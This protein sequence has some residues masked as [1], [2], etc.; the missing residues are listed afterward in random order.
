M[1]RAATVQRGSQAQVVAAML[2]D[3]ITVDR[4]GS[5]AGT[6]AVMLDFSVRGQE[7]VIG[8]AGGDTAGFAAS[9]DGVAIY[10][11]PAT[12]LRVGDVFRANAAN[13]TVE[14]VS[15]VGSNAVSEAVLRVAWARAR[16]KATS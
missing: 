7:S 2:G 11:A 14:Y 16:K 4:G 8:R 13:Y 6:R 15:P 5:S 10:L 9:A 12:D 3:T 1:P